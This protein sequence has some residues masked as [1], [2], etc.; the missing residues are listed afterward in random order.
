MPLSNQGAIGDIGMKKSN[1]KST[2]TLLPDSHCVICGKTIDE[3]GGRRIVA[4]KFRGISISKKPRGGGNPEY[5]HKS[6]KLS[7]SPLFLVTWGEVTMWTEAAIQRAKRAF[8]KGR[9]SWF[10]QVCGQRTCYKCGAPIKL[11]VASDVLN[12]DG[13]SP[14]VHIV[15]CNLGCINPDC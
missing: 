1:I 15:P 7:P 2:P 14:H 9:R 5:P 13:S 12:D 4:Q 10:C 3:V 6:H 8:H 11:P